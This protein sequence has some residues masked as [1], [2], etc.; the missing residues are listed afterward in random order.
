MQNL[1]K[2]RLEKMTPKELLIE[3][4]WQM[5]KIQEDNAKAIAE[6][7]AIREILIAC[8]YTVEGGDNCFGTLPLNL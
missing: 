8:L 7:K 3:I 6:T 4:V 5:N 2:S 1:Q